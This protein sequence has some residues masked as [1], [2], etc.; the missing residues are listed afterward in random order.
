MG[1]FCLLNRNKNVSGLSDCVV[2]GGE[3]LLVFNTFLVF[4]ES[5]NR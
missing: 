4:L 2:A 5:Q 3:K 1:S